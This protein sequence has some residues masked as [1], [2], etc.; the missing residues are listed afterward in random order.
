[1]GLFRPGIT[2]GASLAVNRAEQGRVA[3]MVALVNGAVFI[4]APALFRVLT[5]RAVFRLL[6]D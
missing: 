2:S 5:I 3:G 6:T 1:M 4:A